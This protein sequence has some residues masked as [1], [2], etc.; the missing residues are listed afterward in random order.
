MD[1]NVF[2]YWIGKEYKLITILRQFIYLHLN[3]PNYKIH[4]INDK[5]IKDYIEIIPDYFNKLCP[6][7]QAD[8]V[9]VHVVCDYGGIWL[10][11]DTI[12]LESLDSLFHYLETKE[13]FFIKE[14]NIMLFNGI[15]GSKKNTNLMVE[16]K[17]NI[18][19]LLET[20]NEKFELIALGNRML[21][22]MYKS[23]P[24]LYDNF[25]LLKGLENLYP[26]NW[27]SCPLEF[28]EKPY[29]NYS[30]IVRNFQPLIILVNTVYKKL[31]DKKVIDILN[32][33][34]PLNYFINK[35]AN[36][37]S[38]E[39]IQLTIGDY[40]YI[41]DKSNNFWEEIP[42]NKQI[43][44]N[45][46]NN[47][48]WNNKNP[49]VPLSGPGSSLENTKECSVLL[50]NVIYENN[51]GSVL[52]LGCG[53]LTWISK[54]EFFN[55]D[56]ITYTGIDVVES[57]INSHSIKYPTKTFY[58][59]DLV[60]YNDIS[61]VDVII[62][63]DVVF[64]LKNNEIISIFNNIKNKF[65][66]IAITSCKNN[67]N[68][69]SFNIWRFSEKNINIEPFNVSTNYFRKENEHAFNRYFYLYKHDDFY[70]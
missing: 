35:S 69:D 23:N 46:Y 19:E 59:R 12:L 7:H 29:D 21:D 4:L 8:F 55:D 56:N 67:V 64:H 57:L 33:N 38:E 40:Y 54:T 48:V 37:L 13:G 31:E 22:N 34:M 14:N 53:D 52:D 51:C 2:L 17:K 25:E 26:V 24:A 28:L 18:L 45:I 70:A 20:N 11:S 41:Y 9:R 36:N 5:N 3:Q 49:N 60:S 16:W 61:E 68:T 44:Q 30:T 62:I 47:Q 10:D 43:F 66:Y 39:I 50:N 15:F 1:K 63:R 6:A 42:N 32:G 27:I 58:Q 65:K